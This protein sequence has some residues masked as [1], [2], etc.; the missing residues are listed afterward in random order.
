MCYDSLTNSLLIACKNQPG[1]KNA[2][3]YDKAVY[4]FDLATKKLST[5]PVWMF[6]LKYFSPSAI[7]IHPLTKHIFILSA[8]KNKLIEF[9]LEG[10]IS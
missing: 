7:A 3:K 2:G 4:A 9:N 5:E 8:S 10:K 6:S 1:I